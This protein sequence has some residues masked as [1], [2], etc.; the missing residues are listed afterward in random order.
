MRGKNTLVINGKVYD[1]ITGL[2]V[3]APDP[4]QAKPVA[5]R[6][7]ATVVTPKP[8]PAVK[9]GAS[10]ALRHATNAHRTTQKSVT[11][12]RDVLK[13]PTA[14]PLNGSARRKPQPGRVAKS[15]HIQRFA[16]HPHPLKPVQ[17]KAATV[18]LDI[19]PVRQKVATSAVVAQKHALVQ[20]AVKPVH[21]EKKHTQQL[22]S[23]SVKEQLIS[24]R[25][26]AVDTASPAA[27]APKAKRKLFSKQPR[28]LS[29]L[30]ASFAIMVLGGY[31]T[32]LNMPGLSVRVAAAQADVAASFPD[33][34]PDGY[35]FNG[36]VAF[37]PG[38]V[39]INFVANGGTGK[40]T[41]TEQKSTWD[42]QAVYDN[43]VAKASDENYVT[44][45]QQG[46]TI[47]TFKGKAAWV[48]KGILYTI[49]GDAPLSNEQLLRIA[50][51]L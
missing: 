12:R 43:I 22:S 16:P 48:N 5:P 41:V 11:L 33:Y 45:S 50:G 26:A 28:A 49:N 4:V 47:Y 10:R 44:N 2:P 40:Y 35:R 3:A 29:M 8:Q 24:E 46:L 14:K 19:T 20:P 15:E 39:A 17:P 13:K 38:Q 30:T 7:N 51:S 25:L 42:S 6:V 27:K 36:P 31:L 32:Y 1:A 18:R 23:R 9:E 21:T 37:A 34:H